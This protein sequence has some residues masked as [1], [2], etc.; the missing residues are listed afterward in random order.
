[1]QS[2]STFYEGSIV[3]TMKRLDELLHQVA[4]AA[5]VSGNLP[6]RD[7]ISQSATLIERGIIFTASLYL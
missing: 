6:L 2:H 4:N 5:M 7:K 3:R 1:M